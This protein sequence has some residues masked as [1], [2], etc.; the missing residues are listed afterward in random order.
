MVVEVI[1]GAGGGS[2]MGGMVYA[3]DKWDEG[4]VEDV[5]EKVRKLEIGVGGLRG[6]T[7]SKARV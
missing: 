4:L 5:M 6:K 2:G 3:M 1:G 7:P